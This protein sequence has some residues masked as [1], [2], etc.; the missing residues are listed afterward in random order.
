MLQTVGTRSSSL[1][2][3][4][5]A[6]V[7]ALFLNGCSG[8]EGKKQ[9]QGIITSANDNR[10]YRHIRLANKMD[11]P[12]SDALLEEFK[13]RTSL[14]PLEIS[15]G[16]GEGLDPMLQALRSHFFGE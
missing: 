7:I 2:V 5:L 4:T 14:E 1:W 15:A 9:A 6:T 16:I 12:G 8:P 3:I 11:V 13:T 10:E